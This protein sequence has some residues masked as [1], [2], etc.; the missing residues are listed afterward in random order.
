MTNW[1]NLDF[2][3][4]TGLKGFSKFVRDQSTDS[5]CNG[6][7]R[8]LQNDHKEL[9]CNQELNNKIPINTV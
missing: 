3:Y 1:V 8:P 4:L 5:F 9:L 6:V 7:R 2:F